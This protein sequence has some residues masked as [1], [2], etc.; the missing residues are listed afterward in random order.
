MLS[1]VYVTHHQFIIWYTYLP[2]LYGELKHS[3]NMANVQ[4]FSLAW[5]TRFTALATFVDLSV[6]TVNCSKATRKPKTNIIHHATI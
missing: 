1:D 6:V 3:G 2:V 4:P 5:C